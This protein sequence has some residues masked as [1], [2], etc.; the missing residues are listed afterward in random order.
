MNFENESGFPALFF[1]H[2]DVQRKSHW[3]IVAKATYDLTKEGPVLAPE[4]IPL[5]FSDQYYGEPNKSSIRYESDLAPH[6][7]V[8][9]I[10]VVA[11]AVAPQGQPSKSWQTQLLVTRRIETIFAPAEVT[12]HDPQPLNPLMSLTEQQEKEK[13]LLQHQ[14]SIKSTTIVSKK[15][16]IDKKLY[17]TGPRNWEQGLTGWSLSSLSSTDQVPL[18]YENAYGGTLSSDK[19]DAKNKKNDEKPELDAY[20]FN[21]IG[22]GFLP[23]KI[24]KRIQK[25]LDLQKTI[26]APQ[27]HKVN[28]PADTLH[29][30]YEPQG[31]GAITKVW[32][33]RLKFAGTLDDKW[34]ADTAPYLPSDFDFQ[35]WNAAPHDQQVDFLYGDEWIQTVNLCSHLSPGCQYHS[36]VGN[37]LTFQLPALS[38]SLD[39]AIE[40]LNNPVATLMPDT[41]YVDLLDS[42][43]IVVYRLCMPVSDEI[44]GAVLHA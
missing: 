43:L 12:A 8:C 38:F 14:R 21:N 42:K 9:D 5:W 16:L 7:P 3:T 44:T 19:F 23:K 15:T 24:P 25:S 26:K 2:V 29:K 13:R 1:M 40:R 36:G 41:V 33:Q 35:Y 17:I 32:Q 28:E 11:N 27:I 30:D 10:M 31:Y 4:Q 37:V 22:C 6:K 20:E 34:I 39:L 18:R